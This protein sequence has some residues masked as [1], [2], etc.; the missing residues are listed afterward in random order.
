MPRQWINGPP[1]GLVFQKVLVL[2]PDE[3]DD[4]DRVFQALDN[5]TVR[6]EG[7]EVLLVS[8]TDTF[9]PRWSG[10]PL[11]AKQW[12]ERAW[13]NR[14]VWCQAAW[15]LTKRHVREMTEEV[16]KETKAAIQAFGTKEKEG[17]KVQDRR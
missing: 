7:V 9:I 16:N 6:M 12:A 3:Y 17:Y 5:Y 14:L 8:H 2:G 4:K 15:G 11:Y 10:V 13:W 1:K